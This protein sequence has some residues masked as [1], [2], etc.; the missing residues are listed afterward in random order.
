LT[1]LLV[2]GSHLYFLQPGSES[3]TLEFL[4]PTYFPKLRYA[5]NGLKLYPAKMVMLA[6]GSGVAPMIHMINDVIHRGID[7]QMILL[8]GVRVC[9]SSLS[10]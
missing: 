7:C 3:T 10:S 1:F 8:W 4:G 6:G 5:E 9:L 2:V